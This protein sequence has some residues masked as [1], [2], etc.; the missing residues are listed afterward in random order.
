MAS[1][2]LVCVLVERVVEGHL[3]RL[4]ADVVGAVP[5]DVVTDPHLGR[6]HVLVDAGGLHPRDLLLGHHD[7]QMVVVEEP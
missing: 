6:H 7:L 1:D 4:V 3:L 5:G 2:G